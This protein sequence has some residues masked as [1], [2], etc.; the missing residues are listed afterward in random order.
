MSTASYTGLLQ[1]VVDVPPGQP[2]AVLVETTSVS[3]QWTP[4]EAR[5]VATMP[6]TL[7]YHV[8]FELFM[9]QVR[10]KSTAGELAVYCRPASWVLGISNTRRRPNWS[11]TPAPVTPLAGNATGHKPDASAQL[12]RHP[13]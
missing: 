13:A 5:L 8:N 7:D 12:P 10:G 9:Q 1:V 6:V 11:C 3:L 2:A 4:V